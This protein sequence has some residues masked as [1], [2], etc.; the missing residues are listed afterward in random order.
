MFC[1]TKPSKKSI[2]Q[3]IEAQRHL[4]FSYTEIGA[5]NHSLPAGYTIDHNRIRLGSG[6]AVFNA[7]VAAL[8]NWK[9]FDIGWVKLCFPDT[10]IEVGATVAVLAGHFGFWSL[11]PARIVY[12]V[13][14]ETAE[15]RRFGFAYGTLPAHGE[16]GEERFLI[17]W[18]RD[19]DSVW[20]DLLAFSQ[21]KALLAKLGYPLSR[22]LQRRF[23][24]AS[25]QAMLRAARE[26]V[27][28][29]QSA[30]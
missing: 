6:E 22:M 5:T 28:G 2:L 21:P 25:K 15:A 17:E 4:P 29:K 9:M 16:R 27:V 26:E 11:H 10:P 30:V 14:E 18:R 12:L 1:F 8:R 13:D 20:Y 19:D 24:R 23:A 3:I 7:A